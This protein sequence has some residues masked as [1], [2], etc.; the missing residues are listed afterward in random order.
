MHKLRR[1]LH[2]GL[3]LPASCRTFERVTD[4][5]LD[6]LNNAQFAAGTSQDDGTPAE[7]PSDASMATVHLGPRLW[8]RPLFLFAISNFADEC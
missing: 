3:A 1:C 4:S 7:N 6:E 8:A 5:S 2:R